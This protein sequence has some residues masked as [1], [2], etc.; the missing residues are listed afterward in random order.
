MK[1]SF[2]TSCQWGSIWKAN[3]ENCKETIEGLIHNRYNDTN[4]TKNTD[5]LIDALNNK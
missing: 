3:L 2:I 4:I 5:R 1:Q